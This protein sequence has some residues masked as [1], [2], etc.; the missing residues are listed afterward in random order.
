VEHQR[1]L[2]LL[3]LMPRLKQFFNEPPELFNQKMEKIFR[4]S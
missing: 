4:L 1:E 2:N 3:K